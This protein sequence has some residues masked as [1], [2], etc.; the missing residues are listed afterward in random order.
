MS[1]VPGQPTLIEAGTTILRDAYDEG[2]I[3]GSDTLQYSSADSIDKALATV[4]GNG[5]SIDWLIN[6][7]GYGAMGPLAEMPAGEIER[8][9]ATNLYGPLALIRA[10]VPGMK[11]RGG[12]RIVNVGANGAVKATRRTALLP[13]G[14]HSLEAAPKGAGFAKAYELAQRI[15][16]N[17]PLSNYAVTHALPRIAEQ[18][19]DHGL[20]SEAMMAAIAPPAD[21]PAT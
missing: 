14:V 4:A 19:A 6:N 10:L 16:Q 5:D 20:F 1:A 12:G 21:R 2:K 8:Q 15:A 13:Q 3:S 18:P 17:A 7:A 11:S 9:F